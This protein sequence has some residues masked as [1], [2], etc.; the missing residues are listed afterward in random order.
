MNFQYPKFGSGAVQR[1]V[2]FPQ[3]PVR[4]RLI[5][6]AAGDRWGHAL[7]LHSGRRVLG[8]TVTAAGGQHMMIDALCAE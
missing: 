3:R 5:E 4:T 1:P 8:G 6:M 2:A 7:D